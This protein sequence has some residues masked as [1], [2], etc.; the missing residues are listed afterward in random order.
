MT[1]SLEEL[2]TSLQTDIIASFQEKGI[3][4]IS[5]KYQG[6][7]IFDT[8]R[9]DFEV[10]G[11]DKLYILMDNFYGLQNEE[12]KKGDK[13]YIVNLHT[14]KKTPNVNWST[15]VNNEKKTN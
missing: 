12:F 13:W 1:Y 15:V 2:L 3:E 4:V 9:F 5:C 11:S 14:I 6:V 7:N 10:V 8:F